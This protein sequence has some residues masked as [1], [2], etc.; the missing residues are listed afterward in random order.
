MSLRIKA[1]QRDEPLDKLGLASMT[2]SM[3][4]EQTTESTNEDLSNRLQKLGAY[5]SV[6]ADNDSMTLTVRSLSDTFDE[7]LAVAKERLLKPKFD[8][9]D[10]A[11]V[12]AQTIE[13]I[14]QTKTQPSVTAD[15][16]Y[17]KLLFGE[18]NSFAYLDSGTEETV[19][20]I[21]LDDVKR[22][23]EQHVAPNIAEVVVVS[24]LDKT[25]TM[26]ALG[27]FA[28]WEGEAVEPTPLKPFPELGPTK[29]YLV[30]KPGAAQ[31]EIRIG[32]RAL[33]YDATG[34]FYKSQL[35]NFPIGGT[36]NSRINL[37]LRED[38]GYTYGARSYFSGNEDYG[39]FT[40]QAGVRTDTTADSIV[41]FENEIRGAVSDG[42]TETEM[43]FTRRA[44]GQRDARRY[45]TPSQKL[46]I[47][48]QMIEYDLEPEFIE[49]QNELLASVGKE[50]LDALAKEYM[51]IDNAV[52]VVV[53]DKATIYD[54]LAELG[55]E[56]VELDANGDPVEAEA[57]AA[58]L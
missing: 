47:L 12:K 9:Q 58:S 51:T 2:A 14:R 57:Q 8:E 22:F 48:S 29:I 11:R 43:A 18:D 41:Q 26:K 31:S 13:G 34:D 55:Y 36:F 30:D 39:T 19:S 27:T 38:K 33:T 5:V 15:V 45:E 32:K 1:G 28:D 50:E 46:G 53:G 24:N 52:I 21:T 6:S 20:A 56:I 17:Q 49:Q 7:A 37:N 40:A 54:S 25:M 16:V 23:Y 42:L 4:N 35:A 44:L 10:F 3:L